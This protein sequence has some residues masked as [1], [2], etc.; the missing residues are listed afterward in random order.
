[1]SQTVSQNHVYLI[2]RNGIYYFSRRVPSDLQ[3]RFN[4]E[5]VTV[6]LRTRSFNKAEKSAGALS[7]RLERYW[8]GLRLEM[9]HTKE[10]GLT[11]VTPIKSNQKD[12][13]VSIDAAV[14]TYLRLKGDGRSQTFFQATTR[15]VSYLKQSTSVEQIDGFSPQHAS[16]FR[17]F[18]K[19][20]GMTSTSIRRVFGTVKAIINLTIRE[21]GLGCK[22]VFAD[23]YIPDDDRVDKRPSIP[24]EL[25]FRIQKECMA[26]DDE[27]RRLVSLISDTGMRLAEAVGLLTSDIKL[28]D[29]IPHIKL[30]PHPWRSLKTKASKREIPLVGASLWAAKR[31]VALNNNYAFPTYTNES[32]CA[33]NS[34]SAALNKWLRPRVPIG[35][36]IHSFRHSLRDRLREVECP[37]DIADAIGGWSSS[38]VG[39]KYGSG[40]LLSSKVK[41][42]SCIT[43]G[44]KKH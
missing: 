13:V 4:K 15:S 33:A 12:Q 40:H 35:C 36:V 17:D 6:S 43:R 7:D 38:G 31:I 24:T 16:A 10:L 9:F 42:L 30:M 25:V 1:V 41:Y 21:Y 20:K 19:D 5:R 27:K 22:N 44:T 11:K 37:P 3:T 39:E 28:E 23:V 2:C 29:E 8:E 26:I 18:L 32:K 14:E 34:A